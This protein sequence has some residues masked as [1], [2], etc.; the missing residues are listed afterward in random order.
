MTTRAFNFSAGP[1]AIPTPVLER[2]QAELLDYKG[3]G[4]SVMEMSHRGK[5]FLALAHEVEA[6]LRELM[7]IPANYKVLFL[8]GGGKGEFALIPLNLLRG[9]ASAD[10]LDTGHWSSLAID[11][12]RKYCTPHVV[13][14]AK[15]SG[16]TDVPAPT[17]WQTQRDAAYRH[18]C[19]NETIH[20]VEIFESTIAAARAIDDVPLVAD[21]S[22]HILSR[23]MDVSAFGCIYAGAQKNIGPS[24]LTL[25]IVRDDLLGGA[26]P[27]TPSVFD[28]TQQAKSEWML[29]TPPTFAVYLAGLTFKW[30]KEQGGLAAMD[31]INRRKADKLYASID[32]SQGFY[33]NAV[34]PSY[35]S[36][37]NV[38][39][40]LRDEALNAPFLAEA[41]ARGLVGLKGH[42]A[43]GGMRASIYNAVGMDAVDALCT[44]MD[45][46]ARRHG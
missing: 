24:G 4:T 21:M 30:I 36:R 16:Y 12:A 13:A 20:G 35:R 9:R 27:M 11:E 7:G 25:V 41:E 39:F 28:Y 5:L 46:F 45:E 43:V 14:S 38:P 18:I 44:L 42:K 15:A 34:A 22:S 33:R 26:H 32:Q 29:N 1:A 37:M 6:D 3:S 8:Q 31:E 10:Y 23:P 40:M 2:A 19:T 17:A